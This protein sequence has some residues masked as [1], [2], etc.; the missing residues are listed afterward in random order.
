MHTS[1]QI[2]DALSRRQGAPKRSRYTASTAVAE[3]VEVLHG[4]EETSTALQVVPEAP[5]PEPTPEP[6]STTAPEEPDA[7]VDDPASTVDVPSLFGRRRIAKDQVRVSVALPVRV[8][9]QIAA[10]SATAAPRGGVFLDGINRNHLVAVAGHAVATDPDAYLSA[11][12]DIDTNIEKRVTI[13]GT[14]SQGDYD[15][16]RTAW[17]TL[18]PRPTTHGVLLAAGIAATLQQIEAFLNN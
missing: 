3:A 16:L 14:M 12:L 5:K 1:A 4:D 17:W 10:L 13:Q 9:D 11:A 15:T 6:V 8:H 18:E 7:P 2:Q